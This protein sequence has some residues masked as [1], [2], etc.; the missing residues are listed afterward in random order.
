MMTVVSSAVATVSLRGCNVLI[1][2]WSTMASQI[3]SLTILYSIVCLDADQRKHQSSTSLAFVRG[4]HRWWVNSPHKGPVTWKAFPFDDVTMVFL[5]R[6]SVSRVLS[7]L[8]TLRPRRNGHHFADDIFKRIFFNENIWILIQI[9][10]KSVPKDP[11]NNI[12]ALV[13]IMAW[14]RPGD[15]PLSEPMM[16]ILLTHICVTRPQW[17]KS[18]PRNK[19]L[20]V[21]IWLVS[22][23][24]YCCIPAM[25][26]CSRDGNYMIYQQ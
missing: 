6:L 11:I 9:S 10:L 4:I 25:F 2:I 3:T 14:R 8:N 26:R 13:H 19:S 1:V 16:V 7:F 12:A 18:H 22:Q 23:A 15:K 20:L 5:Q 17:V 21:L 24:N